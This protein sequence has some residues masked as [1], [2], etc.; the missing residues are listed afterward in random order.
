MPAP[1]LHRL[2]ANWLFTDPNYVVA[3]RHNY[4]KHTAL[5]YGYLLGGRLHIVLARPYSVG[6]GVLVLA[7]EVLFW[8]FEA[9]WLWHNVSAA[10]VVVPTYFF[11]LATMFF[12]KAA[13]ADPGVL[14]RNMHLPHGLDVPSG[15]EEYFNTISLPYHSDKTTGVAVKYCPTCHIWRLPR[16][17]HCGV[18]N[19]CVQHH[20]HHCV[21][22]NNCVGYRN[23]RYFLWFL[24][25]AVVSLALLASLGFVHCYAYRLVPAKV[26]GIHSFRASIAAYPVAF[27]LA[28]AG[29]CFVVYPLMLL[30]FHTYLTACNLTTREYLNYVRLYESRYVNVFDTGSVWRN[31]WLAWWGTPQ[32]VLLLRPRDRYVDGDITLEPMPALRSFEHA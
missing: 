32:G 30:V 13:S 10:A 6:I 3:P 4:Q 22:L 11:F 19:V 18:C 12:A 20:D 14:P 25:A 16:M 27:L 17:S 28:L 23:Y 26:P 29:C 21:F 8:V 9:S 7:A 15:P 31:L 1:W 24:V 5:R 2:V